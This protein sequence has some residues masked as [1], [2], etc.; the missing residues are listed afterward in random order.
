MRP[1]RSTWRSRRPLLLPLLL[2]AALEGCEW[3]CGSREEQATARSG[4]ASVAVARLLE[5][6]GTVRLVRGEVAGAATPGELELGDVLETGPDGGAR[7]EFGGGRVVEVG[8]DARFVITE[9]RSGLVLE[10]ARGLVLSRVPAESGDEGAVALNI[11][12]PF[13]L[14]RVGQS[15][16]AVDVGAEAARVDVRVG[17]ID[18]VSRSGETTRVGEGDLL[19][20]SVGKVELLE[21]VLAPA[22]VTVRPSGAAEIRKKDAQ[23]WRLVGRQGQRL[24]PGDS[25]RVREG[26][27][28]L[29]LAGSRSS[30][31]LQGGGELTLE[32]AG[33]AGDIEE[34]R[35]DLKHGE[36]AAN[37]TGEVKSRVVLGGLLLESEQGARFRV[38]ATREGFEVGAVTGD[39][40]LQR[41]GVD[42][43]IRAGQ[44]ARLGKEGPP[45]IDTASR[46]GVV[47]PARAGVRVYHPGIPEVG[48]S[49]EG[50]QGD[51]RVEVAGDSSFARPLLA[52]L[53]HEPYVSAPIPR[54]G[55]LFWRALTPDGKAELARGSAIFA[56]E[57]VRKEL[58]GP[59]NVVPD[60]GERISI[61]YQGKPPAVTFQYKP[62]PRAAKYR[63]MVFRASALERPMVERVA[64]RTTI[65]LEAGTL[66]EGS[67]IWS[68]TPLSASGEELRGGRMNRLELI[69]D[70]SVPSL[71]IHT[72][73]NGGPAGQEV[74]TSGVAPVGARLFINDRPAPLDGKNRFSAIAYPIGTPPVVIYR[75]SRPGVPDAYTVRVL[76]Q[77]R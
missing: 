23:R 60:G 15:E 3:R 57:P 71:V 38:V 39:L 53:V 75:L 74:R 76:R 2:L 69:Y 62:E 24:E 50:G 28:T 18:V 35:V 59:R 30:V 1:R 6:V 17:S 61:Y 63:V 4:D 26:R 32:G 31:E 8:S 19:S 10:V 51:Y 36:L 64:A 70:N 43:L 16:V 22:R 33:R 11:L 34:T 67:Y 55:S 20:L 73:R 7:V 5:I 12:T 44:V 25:L 68:V 46:A 14:T 65:P 41:E 13:G 42:E 58:A 45:A 40:R 37:L 56:P 9:D 47:L 52:G 27:T 29:V 21:R 49:W 66:S 48:L 54:A 77:G 72:P